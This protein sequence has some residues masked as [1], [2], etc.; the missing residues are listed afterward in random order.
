MEVI[1]YT[2]KCIIRG[3]SR[4]TNVK[5]FFSRERDKEFNFRWQITTRI[6]FLSHFTNATSQRDDTRGIQTLI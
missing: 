2:D 5:T 4:M 1:K 3:M 6:I